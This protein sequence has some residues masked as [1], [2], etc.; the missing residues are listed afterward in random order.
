[1]NNANIRSTWNS[2]LSLGTTVINK[3]KYGT[4]MDS[5]LV[6]AALVS[7]P[8][9]IVYAITKFWL[10]L[11]IACVPLLHFI[12]VYE[13]HMKNNPKMLRSERH[14]ETM[15]RIASAMGQ[16]GQEVPEST[17]DTLPAVSASTS[18]TKKTKSIAKAEKGRN[19]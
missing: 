6:M 13:Y 12:R 1:M 19:E 8:C 16:K 11:L 17:I 2:I 5:I 3:T 15:Y 14:E 4:A 9:I 10:L 7:L 18:T